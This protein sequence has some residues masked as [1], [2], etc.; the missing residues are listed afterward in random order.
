MDE[1][2]RLAE[3]NDSNPFIEYALKESDDEG[4]YNSN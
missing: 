4:F 1:Y 2:E 3:E